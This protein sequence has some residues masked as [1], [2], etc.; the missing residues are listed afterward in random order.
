MSQISDQVRTFFENF[1]QANNTFDQKLLAP[2]VGNSLVGADPNGTIQMLSKEDYVTGLS[3]SQEYLHTLGF[4]YIKV[5]PTEEIPL[6]ER[7]IMVKTKGIMRLEKKP[8][9]PIDLAHDASYILFLADNKP[10]IVFALSHDDPMKMAQDQ[11]GFV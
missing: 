6:S 8:G 1:E 11:H 3:K 9:Q 5:V 10:Q 7:Y 4:R 2:L